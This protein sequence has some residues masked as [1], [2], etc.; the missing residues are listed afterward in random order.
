MKAD[1]EAISVKTVYS[2]AE[3]AIQCT[4]TEGCNR[5]NWSPSNCELLGEPI[6]EIRFIEDSNYK[7]FC[8]FNIHL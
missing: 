6:G 1:I 7:H 3:C 8:K 2:H 4:L 5:V